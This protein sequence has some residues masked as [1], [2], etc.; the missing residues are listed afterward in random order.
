MMVATLN[1]ERL[2]PRDEDQV[3]QRI[4]EWAT[5]QAKAVPRLGEGQLEELRELLQ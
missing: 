2:L 4:E 1:A 3:T 5:A